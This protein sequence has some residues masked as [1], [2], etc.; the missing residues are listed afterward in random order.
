[1]KEFQGTDL[2]CL[3]CYVTLPLD[4]HFFYGAYHQNLDSFKM[5]KFDQIVYSYCFIYA[6]NKEIGLEI[7]DD[8]CLLNA[9][10]YD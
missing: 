1:M 3:V 8:L 4:Y 10:V 9:L 6:G 7:L 5:L 2:V